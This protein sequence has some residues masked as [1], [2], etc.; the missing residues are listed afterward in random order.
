MN[1]LAIQNLI[2]T[3]YPVQLDD[4]QIMIIKLLLELLYY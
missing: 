2:V 3:L 1:M 4:K